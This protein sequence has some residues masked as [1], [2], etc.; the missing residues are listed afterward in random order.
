MKIDDIK[1]KEVIDGNGNKVGE[2]EDIDLDLRSQRI[3]GLVLREG[4]LAAKIK[5]GDTR[6]IP[7][8][9]ID[10]IGDKVLLKK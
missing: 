10:T 4:G 2:V 6:T 9:M 5:S 8:N 7:C 3:E 1:G